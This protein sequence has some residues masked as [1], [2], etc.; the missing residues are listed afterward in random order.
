MCPLQQREYNVIVAPFSF[1]TCLSPLLCSYLFVWW[2]R[3]D[4]WAS[5]ETLLSSQDTTENFDSDMP[6]LPENS[7]GWKRGKRCRFHNKILRD[8]GGR[9]PM[10][11][12]S[13]QEA[14]CGRGW[15]SALW[16]CPCSAVCPWSLP[17][18]KIN[19]E[20]ESWE[21]TGD[22][23]QKAA[24]P[25]KE[26]GG[27]GSKRVVMRQTEYPAPESISCEHFLGRARSSFLLG[28]LDRS[29]LH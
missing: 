16:F 17:L 1:L 8:R 29:L 2:N 20:W 21:P 4:S 3:N 18:T 7:W 28:P 9:S 15:C 6:I 25:G 14:G 26:Q 11:E 13:Y 12:G 22:R 23:P 10:K 19:H 5:S 27:A 24:F